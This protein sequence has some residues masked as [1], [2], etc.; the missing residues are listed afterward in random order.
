MTSKEVIED[1][2]IQIGLKPNNWISL[3]MLD[4]GCSFILENMDL[5]KNLPKK[6]RGNLIHLTSDDT[7]KRRKCIC[8]LV[9]R[10]ARYIEGAILRKRQ[11]KYVNKKT[12]SFYS[13]KL[14]K[15]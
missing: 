1:I 15:A 5:L 3:D 4:A 13:Y 14:I 12:K 11:Q 8:A 6:I 7:L 10:L 9:R 2:L